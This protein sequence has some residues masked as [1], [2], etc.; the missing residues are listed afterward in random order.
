[1]TLIVTTRNRWALLTVVASGILAGCGSSEAGSNATKQHAPGAAR[2]RPTTRATPGTAPAVPTVPTPA[3]TGD[4]ADPAAVAVIRAWSDALRGGNVRGAA[5]YFALPS[6]M[7]N[8]ADS[9]GYALVMTIRTG[10]EAR[11]ANAG[12]PCGA[13][14]ISGDQRGRYVNALFRLTDRPGPGGGCGSGTGETVAPRTLP[15]FWI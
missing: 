6:V 12:L 8:G 11:A 15:T 9:N 5:R 14:F 2:S 3:P 10:A 4:A 1:M 7:I 13:R